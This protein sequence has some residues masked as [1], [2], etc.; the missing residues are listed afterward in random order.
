MTHFL[1]LLTP[2]N[3]QLVGS[4]RNSK[5]YAI[6]N[7]LTCSL[8]N[9]SRVTLCTFYVILPPFTNVRC[10]NLSLNQMYRHV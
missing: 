3:V 8:I 9:I 1:V 6:I 10:S 7:V 4:Q 5:S 2:L